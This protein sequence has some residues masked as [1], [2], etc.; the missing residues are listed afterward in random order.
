MCTHTH[1]HTSREDR[2]IAVENVAHIDIVA[3]LLQGELTHAL[4]EGL[5][6]ARLLFI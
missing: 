6:V 2:A 5:E 1:T 4:R 3:L